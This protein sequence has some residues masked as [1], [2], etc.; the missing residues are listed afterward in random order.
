MF[1]FSPAFCLLG[2]LSLGE[3]SKGGGGGGGGGATLSLLGE[4]VSSNQRPK[5]GSLSSSVNTQT[6][7]FISRVTHGS[8]CRQTELLIP[9][10]VYKTIW[11]LY[12]WKDN[13]KLHIEKLQGWA[14]A[15]ICWPETQVALVLSCLLSAEIT[16]TVTRR[17]SCHGGAVKQSMLGVQEHSAAE[18][19]WP[20]SKFLG[21]LTLVRL[22]LYAAFSNCIKLFNTRLNP[23][24]NSANERTAQ[25]FFLMTRLAYT[26]EFS[27]E[28]I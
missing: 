19:N 6:E 3:V 1:P 13:K 24:S 9:Q 28:F 11:S 23:E 26:R 4:M 27:V 16:D 17:A 12:C 7:R 10:T 22:L 25:I 14:N 21:G 15:E 5:M 2:L 20:V 18:L 8:V